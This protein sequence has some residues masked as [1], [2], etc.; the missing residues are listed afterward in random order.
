MLA[1]PGFHWYGRSGCIFTLA[2]N[3]TGTLVACA[4]DD[5]H[6]RLWWL[7]DQQLTAVFKTTDKV[8]CVTFSADGKHIFNGGDDKK[9]S[10]RTIPQHDYLE[11]A[12]KE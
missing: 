9:I 5:N 4:S 7:S 12:L 8:Y 1:D 2:V 11:D 6:V 10:E 3:S